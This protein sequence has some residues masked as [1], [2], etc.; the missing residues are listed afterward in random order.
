MTTVGVGLLDSVEV[1]LLEVVC[2]GL[3]V[4]EGDFPQPLKSRA[5]TTSEAAKT[6]DF[7]DFFILQIYPVQVEVEKDAAM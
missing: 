7:L 3:G 1:G 2:V 5:E 6:A 4:G